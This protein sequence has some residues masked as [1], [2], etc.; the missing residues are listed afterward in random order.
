[1]PV[2]VSR[3]A[4]SLEQIAARF[5]HAELVNPGAYGYFPGEFSFFLGLVARCEVLVF[6]RLYGQVTAGVGK[7]IHHALA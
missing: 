6:E 3:E 4:Q 7:E 1:M 5:P 2:P